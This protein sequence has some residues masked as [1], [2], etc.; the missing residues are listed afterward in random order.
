MWQLVRG[1]RA[2]LINR[3]PHS[4]HVEAMEQSGFQ[5]CLQLRSEDRPLSP[6]KLSSRFKEL[7]YRDLQTS[8]AFIVA[9]KPA[10]PR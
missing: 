5:V 6:S 8:G 10:S 1:N 9:E 7:G 3:L 4:R 2:Y